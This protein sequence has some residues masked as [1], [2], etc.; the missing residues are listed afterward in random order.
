MTRRIAAMIML[1]AA[2]APAGLTRSDLSAA[3]QAFVPEGDLLR[4]TLKTGATLEGELVSEGETQLVVR[5]RKSGGITSSRSILKATIASREAAD[6]TPALA[7][8]LLEFEPDPDRSLPAEEYREKIAWFDEFLAKAPKAS[9][10]EA[11]RAR[12]DVFQKELDQMSAGLEKIEGEW[13]PPVQAAVR[14]FEVWGRRLGTLARRPDFK[15]NARVRERHERLTAERREV[16]RSLP[17]IM[18]ERIPRLLTQRKFDEAAEEVTAFLQFWVGVVARTEGGA[19]VAGAIAAMDFDYILRMQQRIL[20]SYRN[21]GLGNRRP[22]R[23]I[24][25]PGMIYIPGGYFLMGRRDAKAG[26]DDFP[27]H[28]VFVSPFLI[29][30]Y[31]VSNAEYREFVEHMRRTGDPGVAHPDAPPLKDHAAD[32]WKDKALAGDDQP[33]VGVDWFDAYAYAKWKGKRLPTEAEWERAAR[34]TDGRL[35]PWG[36]GDPK[37]MG[38]NFG[39][40]RA[41]LAAEMDRQNPPRAPAPPPPRFGCGCVKRAELPTPPPTKLPGV[42]WPVRAELPPQT[43][44]ARGEGLFEWTKNSESAYGVAH[45]AGNA[46]EWVHDFYAPDTYSTSGLRDPTG[47]EKG[48]VHV[49]RGGSYLDGS[50]AALRATRRGRPGNKQQE[51]GSSGGRPSRPFIGL[52]CAKALDIVA[53]R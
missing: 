25:E 15:T 7:A 4:I 20:D 26:D 24:D 8:K 28:L 39:A 38:A 23:L 41:F 27:L 22:S 42:T 47:P 21:A 17:R 12:R 2:A 6:V 40:G 14:K 5:Q 16:A 11:M 52:R 3:L 49:F 29:D 51:A 31:E 18:Q 34:G 46:A 43:E 1:T 53:D 19:N 10:A 33:A 48:N 45:M 9:A 32:G 37:S 50:S 44:Q 13:L 35:Y 36:N 30:K